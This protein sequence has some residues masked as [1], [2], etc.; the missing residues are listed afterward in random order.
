MQREDVIEVVS[1]EIG[2]E[3]VNRTDLVQDVRISYD[4]G[5]ELEGSLVTYS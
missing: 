3:D 5:D 4:D 1:K 2:S